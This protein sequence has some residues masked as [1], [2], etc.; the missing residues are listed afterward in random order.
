DDPVRARVR[1]DI[2]DREAIFSAGGPVR[3]GEVAG[4]ATVQVEGCAVGRVEVR[5]TADA[6]RRSARF[7]WIGAALMGIA[8]GA[9][10]FFLPVATV[11]RGDARDAELWAALAEA[12]ASLEARVEARTAELRHREQ[13][14]QAL[15]A[16]LVAVQEEERARISRD[17]HDE[18]GQT[19]TGLRLRLAALEAVTDARAKP[20]LDVAQA[21][22][23]SAVEQ[24]R[25]L[26]HRLRPP[27]LDALGL[28]DAVRAHAEEWSA[29]AGLE[30]E[31]AVDLPDEP[32]AEV[33]EVLFRVAQ[34]ALTNVAR[35]AAAS[36]VRLTL[37]EA[38][39]GWRLS[40]Q[41][42]GRGLGEQTGGGLGLIGAR[43]RVERAGGYLDIENGEAG[44]ALLV[45][46]LPAP[47]A[48]QGGMA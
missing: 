11:R 7:V 41:D 21:A 18:L 28:A 4:W 30:A 46:W 47:E 23:D 43:E 17:L 10:L 6:A 1:L 5:L 29:L 34:E 32:P 40:V 44:G 38:D 15:G 37:E 12:N 20:H 16:R 14:L 35:H 42:D 39:D 45:A 33:A 31:V 48:P 25:T 9:G 36:A 3:P 26:A 22:I 8:L 24:V 13:Q 2:A 27:A 19:L